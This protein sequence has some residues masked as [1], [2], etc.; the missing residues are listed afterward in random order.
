MLGMLEI[1]EILMLRGT[2]EMR[3]MLEMLHT[4]C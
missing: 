2:L 4:L 1:M 3:G